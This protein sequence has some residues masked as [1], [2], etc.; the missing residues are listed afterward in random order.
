MAVLR[1]KL[2]GKLISELPLSANREY[3]AGRKDD[4]DIVLQSEKGISREHFKI[5]SDGTNW[6][7]Q[8]MSRY[9]NIKTGGEDVQE[10]LLS[11]G[12][13]FSLSPYEFEFSE[14]I[15]TAEL[16]EKNAEEAGDEKT[17]VGMSP[18]IAVIKIVDDLGEERDSFR[19]EGGDTWLAGRE[20]HCSIVIRDQKVSRKQ[21]EI[22]KIAGQFYITDLGSANGTMLNGELLD[23]ELK[24]L[25]SGDEIQV[26][27]NILKFEIRDPNFTGRLEIAKM[28]GI[29]D[30][31][32]AYTGAYES[33]ALM[34]AS[35][36]MP[37]G[38][39]PYP[40]PSEV[41]TGYGVP[42]HYQQGM[43]APTGGVPGN[44][45]GGKKKFD[46]EKN[47][48]KIIVGAV[49]ILV[50]AFLFSEEPQD[51]NK[52]KAG[53]TQ[54]DPFSKLTPAEQTLVK[55]NYELANNYF[56]SGKY[57]LAAQEIQKV[58]DKV[59]NY[60]NSVEI[61]RLAAE[62]IRLS[63]MQK[64]NARI[65]AAKAAQEQE[66]LK[67]AEI[68]S[69]KISPDVTIAEIEDCISPVI[70]FNPEHPKLV[71]LKQA[72]EM[73]TLAR[74]EKERQKE[75]YNNLV[76]QLSGLFRS[77]ENLEK[78]GQNLEAIAAYKKVV[79]SRLPDPNG[80]KNKASSSISR[81]RKMMSSKTARF[82]SE[83]TK[84]YQA[85]NLKSAILT[86]RKAVAV[87]PTNEEVKERIN[88]YV[89]ELK[90]QMM[91]LYQEG[92][93]EESFGNVD[94]GESRAGAKDK[95]KKIL[96]LDVPDGEY[97]KKAYIKL[98]KYGA[99]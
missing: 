91:V 48:P 89:N 45:T 17:V 14:K 80:L 1:V 20:D 87:D 79:D 8:V 68:C 73:H 18:S 50:L 47:R 26:L 19:L 2:R 33:P 85:G 10:L 88:I 81:I 37:M 78:K 39:H 76:G 61:S 5:V 67:Q 60:L 4:C 86:L 71:E 74:E 29:A 27:K 15:E 96:Q 34:T 53:S 7:V 43:P 44:M 56:R 21:F 93:L 42:G 64:E 46:F 69:K 28:T 92:V 72:A 40:S 55:Q 66:I 99:L 82:E 41:N 32:N 98:K 38:V 31:P 12:L 35:A 51:T 90:K 75:Q 62:A 84:Y 13:V 36:P 97:Y 24:P 54:S 30:S 11:E 57:E 94:G 9:G 95:W 23:S 83:A 16:S 77:A 49:L 52:P 22:R 59:P 3:I 6:H 63:E 58:L 70:A 25:K 65:E